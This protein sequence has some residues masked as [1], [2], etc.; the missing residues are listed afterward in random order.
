MIYF[1]IGTSIGDP[2]PT[3][4]KSKVYFDVFV[5]VKMNWKSLDRRWPNESPQAKMM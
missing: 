1:A 2:Q 5:S 4:L 3:F